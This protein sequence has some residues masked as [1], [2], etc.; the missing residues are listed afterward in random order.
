[1]EEVADRR[2]RGGG[3]SARAGAKEK[4]GHRPKAPNGEG[5]KWGEKRVALF[6]TTSW[7]LTSEFVSSPMGRAL[8]V[9]KT[10]SK[11]TSSVVAGA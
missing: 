5:E 7:E 4:R 2:W 3:K 11:Y 6:V 10:I 8:S 1:M 9:D